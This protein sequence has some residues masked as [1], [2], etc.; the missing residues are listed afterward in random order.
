VVS[1]YNYACLGLG[2]S[3]VNVAASNLSELET[4]QLVWAL[5]STFTLFTGI[6]F[7]SGS[8]Y[9]EGFDKWFG[10]MRA[11]HLQ[12]RWEMREVKRVSLIAKDWFKEKNIEDKLKVAIN[13]EFLDL[14]LKHVSG[15]IYVLGIG[16]IL[17]S[18]VFGE[19]IVIY[20][21]VIIKKKKKEEF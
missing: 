12:R 15:S 1:R 20:R 18:F 13:D 21:V 5:D 7:E 16:F 4:C 2:A 19:E 8:I 14:T 9:K 11:F 17:S 6:A 3:I 10:W